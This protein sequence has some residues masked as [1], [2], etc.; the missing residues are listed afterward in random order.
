MAINTT[1]PASS[2]AAVPEVLD[3]G[4][5]PS[6]GLIPLG[7]LLWQEAGLLPP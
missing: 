5:D 7:I 4:T 2:S 3:G 1:H 6:F